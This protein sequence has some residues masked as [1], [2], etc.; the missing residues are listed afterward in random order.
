MTPAGRTLIQVLLVDRFRLLGT[1][2]SAA[3]SYELFEPY[4]VTG[5]EI[6]EVSEQ[7]TGGISALEDLEGDVNSAHR[8]TV[9]AVEGDIAPHVGSANQG[10]SQQ[11][12]SVRSTVAFAQGALNMFAYAVDDFN[13]DSTDPRSVQKLNAAYNSASA[14]NFGLDASDY[15]EGGDKEDASFSDD[16]S[17]KSAALKSELRT[18]YGRLESN[19]DTEAETVSGM[20]ER[21]PNE[22]DVRTM[23][24]AGALPSYAA[25]IFPNYDLSGVSLDRLPSDLQDMTPSELAEYLVEHPEIDDPNILLNLPDDVEEAIGDYLADYAREHSAPILMDDEFY[26]TLNGSLERFG[27]GV[28]AEFINSLGGEDTLALVAAVGARAWEDKYGTLARNIRSAVGNATSGPFLEESEQRRLANEFVDAIEDYQDK[29]I[30]DPDAVRG[31]ES[32]SLA[33]SYLLDDQFHDDA[34]LETLGDRLDSFERNDLMRGGWSSMAHDDMYGG[35]WENLMGGDEG[36][37]DPMASFM[38]SLGKNEDASLDFFTKDESRQEYW[39]E[40]R[41]WGHDDFDGLMSAL[42]AATTGEQ[43]I[44]DPDNP[45]RAE[46]AASLMSSAVEYLANREDNF[47]DGAD[48]AF[49]PGDVSDA[50]TEHL[51][52]MI[53]TYMPA[54]DYYIGDGSDTTGTQAGDTARIEVDGLGVL[55]DMPVFEKSEL[56]GIVQVAVSTEDGFTEMREG[57]SAYQNLALQ[58]A[59][60]DGRD[61]QQVANSDGRIEGFFLRQ[62]GD[63]EIDEAE[64]QDAQAQAWIDL[65][66]NLTGAIPMGGSVTSALGGAALDL[67]ASEVSDALTQNAEGVLDDLRNNRVPESFGTRKFAMAE[68]LYESGGISRDDLDQLAATEDE[69][70]EPYAT[71]AEMDEW[72]SNGFPSAEEIENDQ[73]LKNFLTSAVGGS[74]N[75]VIDLDSYQGV[76]RDELTKPFADR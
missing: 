18:E 11:N 2:M 61:L 74:S 40:E 65:G 31:V 54:V 69:G 22:D 1:L 21:G 4:P 3:Q 38:S 35:T 34:F 16:W 26:N 33:L 68:V 58:T 76:Y 13:T 14:N 59:V 75:G 15:E 27:L 48:E 10:S 67:T 41:F 63:V 43:N 46:D 55:Q 39:I 20:L 56:A 32:P 6:R 17:T 71:Q 51:A 73:D 72:F 9:D 60:E 29:R 7:G 70:G 66:K 23:Y 8:P 50:G 25:T 53:S 45:D 24:G 42:D 30:N 12:Q 36:A 57:V 19:L 64:N 5:A 49:K 44:D 47:G 52:H 37:Y 28:Q 62:V